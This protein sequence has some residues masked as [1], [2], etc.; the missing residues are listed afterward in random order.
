MHSAG[1]TEEALLYL[2]IAAALGSFLGNIKIKGNGLGVAMVL[3]V[4]LALGA[5]RPDLHIPDVI[6]ILGLAI[7]VYSIGLSSGPS[8]FGTLKSRGFANVLLA[9]SALSI[10]SVMIGVMASAFGFSASAAAGLLAGITTNTPAL[11]TLLD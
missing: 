7:F 2:F 4:G 11:A 3:F 8:F 6:K 10:L 5:A 9:V 1:N